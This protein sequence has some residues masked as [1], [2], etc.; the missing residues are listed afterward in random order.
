MDA[1]ALAVGVALGVTI[2]LLIGVGLRIRDRQALAAAE[3]RAAAAETGKAEAEA[4]ESSARAEMDN[5]LKDL[6]TEINGMMASAA[7]QVRTEFINQSKQEREQD[8][9]AVEHLLTPVRDQLTAVGDNLIALNNERI[10]QSAAFGESV[11]NTREE[12]GRLGEETGRLIEAIRGNSSRGRWGE[13]QLRR[14]IEMA[15]LTK[16]V[17]FNEQQSVTDEEGKIIPDLLIRLPEGRVVVIDS[18][19]PMPA[20]DHD[21][22]DEARR[23]E[24]IRHASD[25]RA[26]IRQL[27]SKDYA[28][29]LS[30]ALDKVIM[31]LP[32]EGVLA[33]ALEADPQLLEVAYRSNVVIT[34]PTTLLAALTTIELVWKQKRLADSAEQVAQDGVR[35]YDALTRFLEHLASAGSGLST[36]VSNYNKAVGS[37]ERRVLPAARDMRN[38]GL[39]TGADRRRPV[40]VTESVRD[41]VA[42][43]LLALE[44][45]KS[46]DS[47]LPLPSPPEE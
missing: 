2:G 4:R 3:A 23:R 31:F 24:A 36:A 22:S 15:N 20:L 30:G 18:K 11:K 14:V 17:T 39:A 8:K 28:A 45:D 34:T 42:V 10:K 9:A 6:R 25:L 35:L 26:H 47:P 7:A 12:I 37:L 21:G 44:V 29:R 33:G 46:G 38:H 40:T 41:I 19:A 1:V 27:A 43:E 5:R 13:V 32:A 16:H